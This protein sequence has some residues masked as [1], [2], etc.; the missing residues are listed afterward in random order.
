MPILRRKG[1]GRKSPAAS[2]TSH[3]PAPAVLSR[4]RSIAEESCHEEVA[5][6]PP[7]GRL[8]E[9]GPAPDAGR[10]LPEDCEDASDGALQVA[11]TVAAQGQT[12]EGVRG[13]RPARWNARAG[14]RN[15]TTGITAPGPPDAGRHLHPAAFGAPA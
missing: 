7:C 11:P 1:S 10:S 4:H 2:T 9:P 5:V 15:R 12:S 3:A 14:G 13:C 8:W 6:W